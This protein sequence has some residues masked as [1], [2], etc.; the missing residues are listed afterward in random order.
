M[1]PVS[2]K[3]RTLTLTQSAIKLASSIMGPCNRLLET[4]R[5]RM[6]RLVLMPAG[7]PASD[8]GLRN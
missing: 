1:L 4:S 6:Q 3:E 2:A 7:M 8:I 5:I